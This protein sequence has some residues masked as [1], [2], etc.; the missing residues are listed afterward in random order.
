MVHDTIVGNKVCLTYNPPAKTL[1]RKVGDQWPSA[2][3]PISSKYDV[4][5]TNKLFHR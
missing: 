1:I 4:T 2:R 3:N 5:K